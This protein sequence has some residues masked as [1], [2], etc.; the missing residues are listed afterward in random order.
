MTQALMHAFALVL[1][2]KDELDDILLINVH[3]EIDRRF[4]TL[5]RA[6]LKLFKYINHL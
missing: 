4:T 3:K 5:T 1:D 2:N 6:I